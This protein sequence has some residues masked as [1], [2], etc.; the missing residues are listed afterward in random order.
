MTYDK[1]EEYAVLDKFGFEIPPVG[2]KFLI[3]SPKG[4]TKLNKKMT[5]CEMLKWAQEG[6]AF[7]ASIAEHTC[8]AG[9]YVLGQ[10]DVE[11]QYVNGE[12][13]TGLQ[14]YD[15]PRAASR[16][17]Q[18]VYKIDRGTINYVAFAP[19]TQLDFNPDVLIIFANTSQAEIL[20]RASTYKTGGMWESKYTA[21]IGCDW[22]MVYPYLSGNLNFT[23][24]G[25][26]FGMRRRKLFKEGMQVISIPYD[27]LGIMLQTLREMPWI[28]EPYKPDGLEYV[29]QLRKNLGLDS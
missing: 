11:K 17:Y 9:L 29:S 23:T 14:V 8:D 21:A 22:I 5:F 12:Y 20:L 16:L 3:K 24:A 19:L 26:G 27:K 1:K 4:I 10:K 7:Y 6:N 13:G 15:S 18:Y 2:V 28:P 25:L